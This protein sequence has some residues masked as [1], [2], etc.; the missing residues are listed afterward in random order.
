M[1][2]FYKVF[3]DGVFIEAFRSWAANLTAICASLFGMFIT[4]L[5]YYG[6][7]SAETEVLRIT[8]LLT[9]LVFTH[10]EVLFG[11]FYLHRVAMKSLE[12]KGGN[13]EL[14]VQTHDVQTVT[15]VTTETR[16][17]TPKV[18]VSSETGDSKD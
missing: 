16:G 14:E 1:G 17:S 3:T 11:I 12:L 18:T 9:A 5:M 13:L 10:L 4:L 7:W 15:K 8:F 6:A 2:K